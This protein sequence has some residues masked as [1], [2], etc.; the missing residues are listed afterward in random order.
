MLSTIFWFLV[1]AVIGWA[2]PQPEW[3]KPIVEK[4]K[5]WLETVKSVFHDGIR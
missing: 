1:G 2:V 5:S 3:A 4:V